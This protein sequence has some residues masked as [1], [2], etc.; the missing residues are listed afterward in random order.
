MQTVA[1]RDDLPLENIRSRCTNNPGTSEFHPGVVPRRSVPDYRQYLYRRYL[2]VRDAFSPSYR[3]DRV[4]SRFSIRPWRNLNNDTV[5][6]VEP[7]DLFPDEPRRRSSVS[8][9]V[10]GR[11]VYVLVRVYAVKLA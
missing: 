9:K 1:A 10:P 3:I 7:A 11:R 5:V 8:A 4:S 6:I 2:S